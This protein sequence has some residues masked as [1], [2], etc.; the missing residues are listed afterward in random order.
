MSVIR[1]H[2]WWWGSHNGGEEGAITTNSGSSSCSWTT[3]ALQTLSSLFIY[4]G[5]ISFSLSFLFRLLPFFSLP[6]LS[7]SPSFFLSLLPSLL[8]NCPTRQSLF[9]FIGSLHW[10]S[11]W[12]W[13]PSMRG[14]RLYLPIWGPGMGNLSQFFL[15]ISQITC[16]HMENFVVAIV[17][18]VYFA[19]KYMYF[20]DQWV[21][22]NFHN[23]WKPR[24][25]PFM[26]P[27]KCF[28]WFSSPEFIL[29]GEICQNRDLI[30]PIW[31]PEHCL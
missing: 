14:C 30:W 3:L 21:V 13:W 22:A 20:E 18:L 29:A 4:S 11:S 1:A 24:K 2:W 6:S 19:I 8:V 17:Y 27:K 31:G 28:F 26:W 5:Y 7:F 9:L 15:Q 25:R 10:L 12:Q 23:S 16:L